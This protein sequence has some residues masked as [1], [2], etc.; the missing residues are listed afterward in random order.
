MSIAS[1]SFTASLPT[2]N[3]VGANGT[4]FANNTLAATGNVLVNTNDKSTGQASVL[5]S[6]F[7]ANGLNFN[8]QSYSLSGNTL[9]VIYGLSSSATTAQQNQA[10]DEATALSNSLPGNVTNFSST[11]SVNAGNANSTSYNVATAGVVG[12]T[13]ANNVGSA[14]AHTN[15]SDGT[16]LTIEN[17]KTGPGGTLDVTFDIT[18]PNTPASTASTTSSSQTADN[19]STT[20]NSGSAFASVLAGL[21][22]SNNISGL[23]T[24]GS[25]QNN[26]SF[27]PEALLASLLNPQASAATGIYGLVAGFSTSSNFSSNSS[28]SLNV[29]A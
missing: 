22:Q 16:N 25:S 9:S 14:F 11:S 5:A 28:N 29:F 27:S 2:Y 23:T 17:I 4:V 1:L 21:P 8:F 10:S 12:Q 26:N 20:F 19:T 7:S 6:N 18:S 15:S 3:S 13:P 24:Q